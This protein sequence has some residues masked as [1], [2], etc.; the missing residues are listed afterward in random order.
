MTFSVGSLLF[1]SPG[2]GRKQTR[3]DR[4]QPFSG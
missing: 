4:R 2:G 1:G 3:A